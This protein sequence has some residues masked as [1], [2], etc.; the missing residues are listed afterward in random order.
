MEKIL[1]V[2]DDPVCLAMLTNR[3]K[4]KGY[5]VVAAT[6]GDEGV[7]L[8]REEQPDLILMDLILPGMHGLE[9]T[10]KIKEDS[11]TCEIPVFAVTSLNSADIMKE[12]YQDG[13]CVFIRKPYDFEALFNY[14][15]RFVAEKK[16]AG[17]KIMIIDDNPVLVDMMSKRIKK[18]GYEVMTARDGMI[19][20]DQ[21]KKMKP[22]LILIDIDMLED[23]GFFVFKILK[24]NKDTKCIPIILTGTQLS[25]E[26][27]EDL[28]DQLGAEGYI[29]SSFK[30]E[31]V[32]QKIRKIFGE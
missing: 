18:R 1:V 17:K 29:P 28:A 13:I 16:M 26:E 30:F 32:T 8:A 31:E 20:V 15:E 24:R 21:V 25:A 14:I 27:L 9:A 4:A 11:E 7:E 10:K 12:C 3:L 23:W 19:R 22:D 6:T 5:N 2:E